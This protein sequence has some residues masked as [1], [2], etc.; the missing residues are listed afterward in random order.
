MDK[1]SQNGKRIN[2]LNVLLCKELW[3]QIV[4]GER[5]GYGFVV[6]RKCSK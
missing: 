2:R 6:V 5:M 3:N 1:K 4:E